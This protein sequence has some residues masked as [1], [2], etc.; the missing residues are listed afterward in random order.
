LNVSYNQVC[1][2]ERRHYMYVSFADPKE[3]AASWTATKH[4]QH[5]ASSPTETVV[6]F[7]KPEDSDP[8]LEAARLVS[9]SMLTKVLG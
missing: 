9:D 6:K 7:S 5:L 2:S 1:I 4:E 8:E 3:T